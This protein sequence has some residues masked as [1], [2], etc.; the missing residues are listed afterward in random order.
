MFR[1][2]LLALPLVLV[3]LLLWFGYMYHADFENNLTCRYRQQLSNTSATARLSILSY[4]KKYAENLINLSHHPAIIRAAKL[5]QAPENRDGYCPLENLFNIHKHE[6]DALILMDTTAMV[7]KR[8]AD[9]TMNLHHM[10][11]IGNPKANPRVAKDSVYFS[12]I[13]ANHKNQKAITLSCPVYDHDQKVGIL[14]WMITIESINNHF[15]H[16]INQDL[17]I[18]FAVIDYDGWL[19]SNREAYQDWLCRNL[20][21]CGDKKYH[22]PL[23]EHYKA[24]P[25][26]GTGKLSL[27]PDGCEVYA[28]WNSFYVG[29]K[30][31]KLIVMMPSSVIEKAIRNHALST[32]SITALLLATFLSLIILFYRTRLKKSK[33]ETETVYLA[34][35]AETQAQVNEER[36]KR[37]TAQIIGQD[38]ERQRISREI[39]DGLGQLL[40]AMRLKLKQDENK[41]K[42]EKNDSKK[43]IS[44]LVDNVIDEVK[45]ISHGLSPV[46][47]SDLGIEK[48]LNR[49]CQDM[50]VHSGLTVE[51]VSYGITRQPEY[52]VSTHIFRLVQEALT[53]AIR[54]A[55]AKEVNIQ[56]LGTRGQLTLIIQDDGKGFEPDSNENMAGNG[57]GNM[58]DRV[59]ILRGQFEIVTGIGNGTTI[60]IKI[61]V[62]HE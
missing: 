15:L 58:R 50:A 26:D 46:M 2:G 19:L 51:F 14:R 18:H 36:H 1:Y 57:I 35:L 21:K 22:G 48:S 43:D 17:L 32:Y 37:L 59:S 16:T 38:R 33:L 3:A 49:Y 9:D 42:L 7:I 4:F 56:L 61:P 6:I 55:D 8:I 11:C 28:A 62:G 45:R 34:K 40:M 60:T 27:K 39:H 29:Q 53:N 12:D 31:W 24:L 41:S 25:D 13:F 47:L 54:H 10:M 30:K 52:E 23:V 44:I 20:C 5:K